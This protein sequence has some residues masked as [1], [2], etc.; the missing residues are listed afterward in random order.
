MLQAQRV[1]LGEERDGVSFASNMCP[2]QGT[3]DIFVEPVLP[4]PVL[5]V[6]AVRRWP[7]LSPIW[8]GGWAS[9]SPSARPPATMAVLAQ[10]TGWSRVSPPPADLGDDPYVVISTQGSGDHDALAAAIRLR[11]SY[12]AFVGSRRKIAALKSDL[13]GEGVEAAAL[14]Q[15]RAPAGLDIGAITPEEIALSIVAEMVKIRR[16]GQREQ[17]QEGPR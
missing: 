9:S 8:R 17:A 11:T 14:E 7:W 16:L 13:A 2:S 6:L 12:F 1:A 15:I 10:S 5:V 4:R 3:M